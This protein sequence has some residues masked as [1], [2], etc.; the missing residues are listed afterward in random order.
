MVGYP[1]FVG[2]CAPQLSLNSN[3]C[4][5]CGWFIDVHIFPAG[6]IFFKCMYTVIEQSQITVDNSAE[7]LK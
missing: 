4:C 7:D 5:F 1:P 3:F 6:Y 2:G